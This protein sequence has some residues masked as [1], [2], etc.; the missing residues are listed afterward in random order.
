MP[1]AGLTFIEDMKNLSNS[2]DLDTT[3]ETIDVATWR[4]HGGCFRLIMRWQRGRHTAK[5]THSS[6]NIEVASKRHQDPLY[7]SFTTQLLFC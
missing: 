1:S 2:N 5:N 7:P 3:F 6:N 4:N